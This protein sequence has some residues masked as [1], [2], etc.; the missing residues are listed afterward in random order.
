MVQN[1]LM[2][3]PGDAVA[4]PGPLSGLGVREILR[5]AFRVEPVSRLPAHTLATI[6]RQDAASEVL[7]RLIQLAIVILFSALYALSAK[8]DA[9]TAFSPVP[10]ALALYVVLTVAGLRWAMRSGLPAWAVYG[11]I[12]VD[13]ALLM[14]VIWSF[15]IQ[16]AQPASFY[17]KAPTLLYVFIFIA[18][19]ALCFQAR[20]VLA[21]G[22]A[23]TAGWA[24][25]VIYVIL[26]DGA[27]LTVTRDY[28]QYLTSN[29]VLIGAEIDKAASI[30][31]VAGVLWL[32]L[33]RSRNLL[34]RAVS[35]QAAAENFSHFFDERVARR[36]RRAGSSAGLG[37]GARR[38]AAIL[39]VDLRGFS[40]LSAELDPTEVVAI[41]TAYQHRLVPLIQRHGG[42]IDKYLGDGIMATFGAL[43]KNDQHA[44]DALRAVDA[45]VADTLSWGLDRS[46]ARLDPKGVNMAVAAGPVVAGTM[47]DGQRLEFTVIGAAVNLAAK[48]EKHNKAL[49]SRALAPWETYETAVAQG[50]APHR[51]VAKV[52]SV[53]GGEPKPRDFAVLYG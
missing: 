28:V 19:R 35:E 15:H 2:A 3:G 29:S 1:E 7:V 10:Y 52:S 16:Y 11:S 48:L 43:K 5:N 34:V 22:I 47:G 4:E 14:T 41:L 36:I 23:A 38:E 49:G 46:L 20:F 33:R 6:A 26:S 45:V 25:L 40:T 50:Y 13:V 27:A 44:A 21:A 8:T 42:T 39:Y 24:V 30:L 18:L 51:E 32:A 53:L 9:G 37:Q 31:I 12:G 17:L